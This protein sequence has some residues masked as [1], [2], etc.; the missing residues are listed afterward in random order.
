MF[1][2]VTQL[3]PENSTAAAISA[4]IEAAK[5][6]RIEVQ[7]ALAAAEAQRG[8]LLV[9]GTN[10]DVEA[11]ETAISN[12]ATMFGQLDAFIAALEGP[13]LDA[14]R[15]EKVQRLHAE[16]A[17]INVDAVVDEFVTAWKRTYG[18]AAN[19]IADLCQMERSIAGKERLASR[20]REQLKQ[21]GEDVSASRSPWREA[22]GRTM[23][24]VGCHSLGD[25]IKLPS[26]DNES[27]NIWGT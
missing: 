6:R 18:R 4:S 13:L 24:S 26:A 19:L 23:L 27:P 16:Y 14:Q 25:M 12:A 5:Q 20:I 1:D 11:N 22:T 2:S 15:R 17:Q 8:S 7:Q 3:R 21:M 9:G 10:A